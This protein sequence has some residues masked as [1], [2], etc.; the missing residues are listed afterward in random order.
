VFVNFSP[1]TWLSG[2]DPN[3]PALAGHLFTDSLGTYFETQ[4]D[5]A[6]WG[7]AVPFPGNPLTD[8]LDLLPAERP[9]TDGLVGRDGR[10]RVKTIVEQRQQLDR[11]VRNYI[12]SEND[13]IAFG[14]LII[15]RLG[16]SDIDSP[17]NV[18]GGSPDSVSRLYRSGPANG[19]PVAFQARVVTVF[20][21][22]GAEEPPFS[23]PFPNLDGSTR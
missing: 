2:P 12:R 19:S 21:Q 11:T 7:Q 5:A 10:R 14:S 20:A 9:V 22:G 17:Y 13:T 1:D 23:T 15:A 8:T 3:D 16:G 6:H 18:R 4:Q